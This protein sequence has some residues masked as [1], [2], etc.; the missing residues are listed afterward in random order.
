MDRFNRR[1]PFL[2]KDRVIRLPIRIF[3]SLGIK[4]IINIII[5]INLS[6]EII[7]PIIPV[8]K[9]KTDNPYRGY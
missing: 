2:D 5:I 7:D 8:W 6:S 3:S 4:Y 1:N 9:N